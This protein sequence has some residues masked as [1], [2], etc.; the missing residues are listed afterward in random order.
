MLLEP[1]RPVSAELRYGRWTEIAGVRFPTQR[2]NYHSG[3]KLAEMTE[4]IIHVNA[5]LTAQELAAK[6]ADFMP[7][8]PRKH[9][10][11]R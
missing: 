1:D 2:A 10:P 4:E 3:V 8:I 6:P 7:E 5:G 11:K 9:E